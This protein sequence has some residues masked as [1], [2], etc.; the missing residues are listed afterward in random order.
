M[1]SDVKLNPALQNDY[2]LV[3]G[4]ASDRVPSRVPPFIIK[5]DSAT[6]TFAQA[7]AVRFNRLSFDRRRKVVRVRGN[8]LKNP[9]RCVST[10]NQPPICRGMIS[11]AS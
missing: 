3:V 6:F 5:F 9:A 8:D 10:G 1:K 4:L 2:L 7:A 11:D